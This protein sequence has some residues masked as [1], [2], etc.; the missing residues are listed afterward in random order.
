MYCVNSPVAYR[1]STGEALI[2]AVCAAIGAL[3]GWAF[4]DFVAKNLEL[5][6]WK[7]WTVRAAVTVGGTAIGWVAGSAITSAVASF[8]TANPA[9]ML[10]LAHKL[11]PSMFS[12][13]MKFL[14]IIM[15]QGNFMACYKTLLTCHM[16]KLDMNGQRPLSRKHNSLV[17]L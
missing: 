7:Y 14:G 2:N 13:A 16:F 11:G 17:Y 3:A 4:G 15:I 10:S 5:E 1:D 12:T 8:L 6:G 9:N